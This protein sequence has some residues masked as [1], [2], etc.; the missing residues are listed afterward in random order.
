VNLSFDK[1]EEF[2]VYIPAFGEVKSLVDSRPERG[3]HKRGG[4]LPVYVL[5]IISEY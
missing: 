4:L 2:S 5:H 1:A 3:N